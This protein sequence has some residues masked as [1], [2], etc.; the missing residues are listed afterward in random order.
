MLNST[1]TGLVQNS[2]LQNETGVP[3]VPGAPITDKDRYRAAE[4]TSAS[5]PQHDANTKDMNH[6]DL[7]NYW[8]EYF[9]LQLDWDRLT[10]L[11]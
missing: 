5:A 4:A 2:A 6:K 7:A 11:A 8:S 10:G 1:A 3:S 9:S